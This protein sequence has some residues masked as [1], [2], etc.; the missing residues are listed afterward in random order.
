MNQEGL[1]GMARRALEMIRPDAIP[2]NK[3]IAAAVRHIRLKG[4]KKKQ[5]AWPATY[6]EAEKSPL[7][8]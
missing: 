7:W 8:I 4:E 3:P 5:T 1:M 2:S 6:K